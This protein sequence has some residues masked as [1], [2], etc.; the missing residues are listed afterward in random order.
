M[1]TVGVEQSELIS[2]EGRRKRNISRERNVSDIVKGKSSKGR[3]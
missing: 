3:E 1:F 2:Q